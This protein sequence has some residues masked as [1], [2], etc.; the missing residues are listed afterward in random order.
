ML[1]VTDV[2]VNKGARRVQIFVYE[3]G[4]RVGIKI[5]GREAM[6]VSG[7]HY[8]DFTLEEAREMADAFRAAADVLAAVKKEQ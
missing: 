4:T 6:F 7:Y 5:Q 1:I 2:L 3:E 8:Q